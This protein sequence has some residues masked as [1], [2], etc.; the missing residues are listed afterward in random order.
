MQLMCERRCIIII[1]IIIQ[2]HLKNTQPQR[3]SAFSGALHSLQRNHVQFTGCVIPNAKILNRE[4]QHLF[5][6]GV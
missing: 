2:F 1:I 3:V 4:K 6:A 5:F